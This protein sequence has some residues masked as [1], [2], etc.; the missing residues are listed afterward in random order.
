MGREHI[1]QGIAGDVRDLGFTKDIAVI[2]DFE[3]EE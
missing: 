3:A 2:E 1:M